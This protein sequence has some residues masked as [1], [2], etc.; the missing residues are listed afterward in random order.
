MRAQQGRGLKGGGH[1]GEWALG[2]AGSLWGGRG[3]EGGGAD[4]APGRVRMGR[5]RAPRGREERLG[6]GMEVRACTEEEAR[7]PH[8]VWD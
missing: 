4:A 2:Q 3:C 6:T 7:E 8:P 5:K 1:V